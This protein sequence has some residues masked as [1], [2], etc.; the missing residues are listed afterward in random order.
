MHGLAPRTSSD[1]REARAEDP[2]LQVSAARPAPPI[3]RAHASRSPEDDAVRVAPRQ[4]WPTFDFSLA[5]TDSASGAISA[6]CLAAASCSSARARS[7]VVSSA[8]SRRA[9]CGSGGGGAALAARRTSMS[10]SS[11]RAEAER[12][13]VGRLQGRRVPVRALADRLDGRLGGADEAHDLRV[14]QLRMVAHQPE[15]GVR[16][17][18]ALRDRRVARA[19]ALDLRH[20]HLRLGNLHAVVRVGL[21]LLDLFAR[22]LAG[23][24]RVGA[25]DPLRGIAVGDRLHLERMQHA[26]MRD[27]LEGQRRVFDQPDGGRLGHERCCRQDKILL[28][29]PRESRARKAVFVVENDGNCAFIYSSGGGRQG[30]RRPSPSEGEGGCRS[31]RMRGRGDRSKSDRPQIA[32]SPSSVAFGDTLSLRERGHSRSLRH[33]QDDLADVLAAVDARGAPRPRLRAEKSCR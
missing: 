24:D 21:G 13:R 2:R 23:E 33:R 19:A 9:P 1:A 15:D 18:L 6:S 17:V 30:N 27:L 25:L 32:C 31:S 14:L 7:A 29:A 26:E 8:E 5:K 4:S 22:E 12:H 28:F 10:S 20:A 11:W 16:P 3:L